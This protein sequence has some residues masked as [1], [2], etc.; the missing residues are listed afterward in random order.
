MPQRI[1]D[2]SPNGPL[3]PRPFAQI[4]KTEAAVGR[5]QQSKA[6]HCMGCHQLLIDVR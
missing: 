4:K 2:P 6:S 1:P 5:W 3:S